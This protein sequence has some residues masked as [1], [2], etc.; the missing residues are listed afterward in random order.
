[1]QTTTDRATLYDRDYSLWLETTAQQLRKRQ[2]DDLDI[3]N[4]AEEIEA[5]VKSEKRSLRSHLEVVL[6]HLLKYKYHPQKR[7][8]SWHYTI[9]EHRDRIEKAFQDSPS[10][11]PYFDTVFEECY[12]VARKKVAIEMGMEIARFPEV[13]PFSTVET[14]DEEY[15]PE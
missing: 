14:L 13:S 8:N 15:L 9:Y 4:L 5:M 10:L 12:K 6:M 2:L 7:T 11:R 1:M 3:D